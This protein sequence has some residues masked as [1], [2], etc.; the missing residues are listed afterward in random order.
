SNRLSLT[1]NVTFARSHDTATGFGDQ[2][3]D[4]RLFYQEWGPSADKP[5]VRSVVS[6]IYQITNFVAFS[7]IYSG[8]SGLAY[9]ARVGPASDLNGDTRVNG[10]AP[11]INRHAF[12]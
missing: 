10:P 2:A 8:R 1:G 7:G 4:Q 3:S 6:W 5:R 12:A 11:G 9:D